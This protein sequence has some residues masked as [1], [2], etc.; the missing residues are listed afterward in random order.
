MIIDGYYMEPYNGLLFG[1]TR[2]NDP[3]TDG[4]NNWLTQGRDLKMYKGHKAHIEYISIS[5]NA[6]A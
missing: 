3:N 2:L 6:L 1:G 4:H 5:P